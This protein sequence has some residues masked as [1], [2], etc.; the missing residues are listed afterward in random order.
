LSEESF[1]EETDN[2]KEYSNRKTSLHAQR[3]IKKWKHSKSHDP[4]EFNKSKPPT[5]DGE[6]KKGEEVEVW[7]L[8]LKKYFRFHEYF[9]H[10]K[11]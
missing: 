4:K 8:V 11:V 9:E 5:F 6:I 1:G 7:L 2:S 10:L 3:K